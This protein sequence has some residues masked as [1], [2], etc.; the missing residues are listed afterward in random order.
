[1]S[2]PSVRVQA[3]IRGRTLATSKLQLQDQQTLR[4]SSQSV[5]LH[6]INFTIEIASYM[7]KA[8]SSNVYMHFHI[9]VRISVSAVAT[10]NSDIPLLAK[11]SCSIIILL[12]KIA[13]RKISKSSL[14]ISI[15]YYYGF[16]M[17]CEEGEKGN[18]LQF[19]F[20]CLMA[21]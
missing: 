5:V 8:P 3:D 2:S 4:W 19:T 14:V 16:L 10:F 1:M 11:K 17:D 6:N 7:F 21:K 18:I 20:N 9:S 13:H 15:G 12:P